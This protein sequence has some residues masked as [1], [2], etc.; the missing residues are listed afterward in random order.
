MKLEFYY[1]YNEF[2]LINLCIY[3]EVFKATFAIVIF[4]LNLR[5]KKEYIESLEF[6]R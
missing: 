6:P 2:Y 5:R 1:E 4:F 3:D